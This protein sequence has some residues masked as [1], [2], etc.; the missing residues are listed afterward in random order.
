MRRVASRRSPYVAIILIMMAAGLVIGGRLLSNIFEGEIPSVSLPEEITVTAEAP[1]EIIIGSPFFLNVTVQ[2]PNP[3]NIEYIYIN[4]TLNGVTNTVDSNSI[5]FLREGYINGSA[6]Y[7]FY[8]AICG[9]YDSSLCFR[10]ER[11]G[12]ITIYPGTT[13]Y[14]LKFQ[15]NI[16]C[17]SVIYKV[18]L[19][20]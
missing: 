9:I 11:S 4:F 19:S 6:A 14:S 12:Y 3:S 5:T 7:Y 10:I 8:G 16:Q 20:T 15:V 13:T 18:W 17:E 2:N 1:S